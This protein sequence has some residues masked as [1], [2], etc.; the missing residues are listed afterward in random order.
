MI[1]R[2]LSYWLSVV[3][4]A[5]LPAISAQGASTPDAGVLMQQLM[6]APTWFSINEGAGLHIQQP[7]GSK[8]PASIPFLVQ[9]IEISG[10]TVLPIKKLQALVADADGKKLSLLE[11]GQ[12]AQRL[13]DYYR[14]QGY[15]LSRAIIPVQTVTAGIVHMVII[16]GRYGDVSINNKSRVKSSVLLSLLA[17][18]EKWKIISQAEL[19]RS[20]LLLS[21]ING[22]EVNAT[23]K[24]GTN[25]S[26]A[27]MNVSIL[28][29]PAFA[30]NLV[31]DNFGN[32]YT[33]Q[34][35]VNLALSY[36]NPL[37]L[38]DNLSMSFL[39]SGS[40]VIYGRLA[41]EILV[42]GQGSRAGMSY[43]NMSYALGDTLASLQAHGSAVSQSLWLRHPLL[44]S[45]SINAYGQLQYDAL[46]MQDQMNGG[47]LQNIR[48]LQSFTA[49]FNGDARDALL[50]GGLNTWSLGLVAGKASFGNV[51]AQLSDTASANTQGIFSKWNGNLTRLQNLSAN[52][53]LFFSFSGQV[54]RGNLDSSQKISVGGPYN[55][56]AYAMGSASGD[57]AAILSV[58]Y[59]HQLGW[60]A[61][62]QLSATG[63]FD[64]AYVVINAN[65][66]VAGN[67]HTR[68]S[69]AGLGLN[70]THTQLWNLRSVVAV[71]MWPLETD[72]TLSARLWF[73]LSKGF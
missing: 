54:A 2:S 26:S 11:L 6:P 72:K 56:R 49:S 19:D 66:W 73:T 41:Y 20:L 50:S 16:E 71:P 60:F 25:V 15:P 59:R 12:L 13:T 27:D 61:Q 24:P 7:D 9:R 38:G 37:H 34:N 23:L 28:P 45:R 31:I 35:R 63:F 42:N 33:G 36:S 44:R 68:L 5:F 1:T 69:G 14:E 47:A 30:G 4:F 10:H 51:D 43:S 52:D 22:V 65:P 48:Q 29:L 40:G 70:W 55:V 17:P 67:N 53:S 18:M 62:G 3:L 8:V 21:D 64:S 57:S 58:E 39:S 46:S 32:R